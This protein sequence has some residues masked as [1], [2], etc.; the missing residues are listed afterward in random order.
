MR[1]GPADEPKI[2]RLKNKTIL[3]TG[4]SKGIGKALAL[5]MAREGADLIVNYNSDGQG[6]LGVVEEIRA[7]GR[8]AMAVQADI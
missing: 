6:A 2:M 4:A 7:M 8:L 1:A 5:G 3:V